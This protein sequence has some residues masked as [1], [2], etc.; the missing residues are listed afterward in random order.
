M[1]LSNED[2]TLDERVYKN[3]NVANWLRTF[4]HKVNAPEA[5]TPLKVII[6]FVVAVDLVNFEFI[7]I[8]DEYND[9]GNCNNH[10]FGDA[11]HASFRNW[12]RFT[13]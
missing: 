4:A 7:G 5:K 1:S 10:V 3:F 2:F 11:S 12:K 8:R 9:E 13:P 6:K